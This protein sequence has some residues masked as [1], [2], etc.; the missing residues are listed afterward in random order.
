MGWDE[1]EKEA[2]RAREELLP[3]A[4][5]STPFSCAYLP[6]VGSLLLFYCTSLVMHL[7]QT[8][9]VFL[10]LGFLGHRP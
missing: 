2:A 9:F 6:H 10:V 4:I 5:P 8:E 3:S 7:G 1:G